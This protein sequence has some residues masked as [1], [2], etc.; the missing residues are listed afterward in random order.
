VPLLGPFDVSSDGKQFL[1]VAPEGT[2][3]PSPL[4]VI[5]NWQSALPR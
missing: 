2:N 4:R 5:T 1:H 3:A